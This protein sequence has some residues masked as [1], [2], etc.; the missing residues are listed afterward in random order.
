MPVLLAT[1]SNTLI[2]L[3]VQ[4]K[5]EIYREHCIVLLNVGQITSTGYATTSR[6][7]IVAYLHRTH[8]HTPA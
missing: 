7:S 1:D 6:S 8:T 5:P 3:C 2:G 4:L